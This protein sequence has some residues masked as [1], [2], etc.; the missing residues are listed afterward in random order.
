MRMLAPP[1]VNADGE[2]MAPE[3]ALMSRVLE[4]LPGTDFSDFPPVKARQII[5]Q[6]ALAV[7]D[8]YSAFE[9][10]EDL[11][12]PGGLPAT[13]YRARRTTQGLVL[14]FHGGGFVAGSRASTDS[15]VRFIAS[16][17]PVDVLSVD[18]RLAPEHPF[19]AALSDAHTAWDYAV[20]QAPHQASGDVPCPSTVLLRRLGGG[21]C[22][23][24]A[25]SSGWLPLPAEAAHASGRSP[26]LARP[27][28]LLWDG[29]EAF[30]ESRCHPHH[31][32][33][34]GRLVNVTTRCQSRVQRRRFRTAVGRLA[35]M[36]RGL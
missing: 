2:E 25:R 8:Q 28:R 18:Y 26:D 33:A 22:Q 11:V 29:L 17:A 24:L 19:P 30:E 27:R 21:V 1:P 5:E 13:R 23:R 7:A 32:H 20:A 14:Y 3:I 34:Q 35:A 10:E 36:R 4:V 12:L 16:G 15:A 31:V 6:E 9:I